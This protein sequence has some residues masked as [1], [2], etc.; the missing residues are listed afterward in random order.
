MNTDKLQEHLSAIWRTADKTM[1]SADEI[2]NMFVNLVEQEGVDYIVAKT[3][4]KNIR[5]EV[6]NA[7]E[8]ADKLFGLLHDL[9]NK[10]ND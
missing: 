3:L 1:N 5:E 8:L 10:L 4:K 7:T 9:N 2:W 6:K